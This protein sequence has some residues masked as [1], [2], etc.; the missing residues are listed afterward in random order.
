MQPMLCHP[1]KIHFNILPSMRRSSSGLFMFPHQGP[2]FISIY[3]SKPPPMCARHLWFDHQNS[4]WWW[5]QI[6]KLLIIKFSPVS[7]YF[8]HLSPAVFL[9][10]LFLIALVDIALHHVVQHHKFLSTLVH[11][12]WCY[13]AEGHNLATLWAEFYAIWLSAPIHGHVTC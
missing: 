9:I 12:A 8:L 4:I 11:G 5:V 13:I 10:A 1:T 7:Y 3:F 6:K 2:A